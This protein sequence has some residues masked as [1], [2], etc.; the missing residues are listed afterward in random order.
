[1]LRTAQQINAQVPF[2]DLER[3]QSPIYEY[4]DPCA[5]VRCAPGVY[6][7]FVGEKPLTAKLAPYGGSK[8][9][10]C[11]DGKQIITRAFTPRRYA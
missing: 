11:P 5:D 9:C 4:Y 7:K 2:I 8:I 1:M 6:A 10:E 3:A